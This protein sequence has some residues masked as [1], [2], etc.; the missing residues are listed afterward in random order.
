MAGYGWTSY[1][2]RNGGSQT[3]HDV[4][5]ELDLTTEFVKKHEGQGAGNWAL[6]VRG[7]HKKHTEKGSRTQIV[8]YAGM[9]KTKECVKCE[10]EATAEEKGM[11][12]DVEVEE[13]G[14][15]I[16]HP[17]LGRAGMRIT[18]LKGQKR[19]KRA[20]VTGKHESMTVKSVN[21]TEDEIWQSKCKPELFLEARHQLQLRVCLVRG[22]C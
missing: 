20:P 12:D 5:N 22:H 21:V 13:V 15:K 18:N 16:K 4:G 10:M 14:I 3:M 17:G 11:G 9:E 19:T 1:D 7:T 6:R 8:F 2:A